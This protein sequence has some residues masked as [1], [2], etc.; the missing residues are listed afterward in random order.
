M[1]AI[2]T[3]CV[4]RSRALVQQEAAKPVDVIKIWVD[5]RLGELPKITPELYGAII[6]EAHK[7]DLKVLAH[8]YYLEDAKEL[9]RRGLDALAHSVR[10]QEVDEEFLRLAKEA[11]ITQITTLVGHSANVAYAEGPTFL[12]DPGLPLLFPA[13][14][15]ETVG[16]KEYQ[17][18]VAKNL[19]ERSGRRAVETTMKNTARVSAAGIPIALGTD[20][21]GAGRFQGLS[22]HREMELLVNAGLTPMQAIRAATINAAKFLGVED[23]YGTLEPGKVADFILL[24]ANPLDDITNSRKIEAVWMNG[25]P[26]NRAALASLL[27]S[28]AVPVELV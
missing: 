20:S 28:S 24:D 8:I 3:N 17:E 25:E 21:S 14:V 18:M 10:D 27:Y 6:D 4:G 12:D 23:R 9:I 16:S 15:L 22:E 2:N 1:A 26:V 7:H 19:G 13:S 11:G 5:D